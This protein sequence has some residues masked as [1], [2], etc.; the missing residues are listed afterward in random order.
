M[1]ISQNSLSSQH[2]RTFRARTSTLVCIS[3]VEP[4]TLVQPRFLVLKLKL[5]NL[6]KRSNSGQHIAD[7]LSTLLNW[8]FSGWTKKDCASNGSCKIHQKLNL[9]WMWSNLEQ[10]RASCWC[11]TKF[12]KLHE[13]QG[14]KVRENSFNDI[15]ALCS[16]QAQRNFGA[17]QN[18][19]PQRQFAR[20]I[21]V[22]KSYACLR[23]VQGTYRDTTCFKSN[24][25]YF[26]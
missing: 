13:I 19:I 18:V 8:L 11:T 22:S 25:W 26:K 23:T 2:A 12:W 20:P 1:G 16:M 15:I 24:V 4:L 21:Y 3:M 6:C 10:L 7:E 5:R 9:D 14:L 17:R